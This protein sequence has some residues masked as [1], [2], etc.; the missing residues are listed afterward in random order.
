MFKPAARRNSRLRLALTGPAGAGKTWTMLQILKMLD[1]RNVGVMDSERGASQKYARKANAPEGPGNW[2]FQVAE[3]TDKSPSEY[4]L[5]IRTAAEVGVD[6]LG[7]DSWSHSWMG[8]L[9]MIDRLGGWTKGGKTVSPLVQ[10]IV[11][12][13]LSYPGHVVATMRSKAEHVIEK[14]EKTGKTTMRKVGM[15]AVAREG[16]EFEFD[17]ILDLAL[18]GTITVQKTR[19]SALTGQVFTRDD[20]PKIVAALRSWLDEGAPVSPRDAVLERIRFAG[21]AATLAAAREAIKTLTDPADREACRGP[22]LAKKA[23]IDDLAG[24]LP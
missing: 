7:I 6:G 13:V 8:A 21:D 3:L 15:A 10:K 16:T 24:A 20:V 18:D 12:A 11:D 5:A 23:E 9:E 14:D 22:Y 2:D 19:C 4:L 17:V 1:V